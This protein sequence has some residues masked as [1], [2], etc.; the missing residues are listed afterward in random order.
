MTSGASPRRV[1]LALVALV[2]PA[3]T[4]TSDRAGGDD[5]AAL[6]PHLVL[7]ILGGGVRAAD[8]TDPTLMPTL[9]AMAAAKDGRALLE[10]EAGA[11]DGYAGAARLLT[12]RNDGVDGTARTR[13]PHP[14]L[15]EYVRRGRD[16][17][18]EKVWYVSFA[19]GDDLRLAWSDHEQFG[20]SFAPAVASGWGAFAEP[21]GA[22]LETFGRPLPIEAEAW[23]HLRRLRRM[24]RDAATGLLPSDV[25][26]GLPRAEAV[27][28]ALLRELDRK[29]LLLDVPN[30]RDEQALRAART[31]LEIHRPVLTI[32]R[33]G[34]AEQAHA[35]YA[36]Y[37]AVLAANDRGIGVLR[38]V[39]DGD[40]QMAARTIFA[41]VADRGRNAQPDAAGALGAD[42]ASRER[43][44]VAL[45]IQG[46]GV[47]RRG[48]ARIRRAVEDVC[49]TLGRLL[50]VETP[51]A[52]G[53]VWE[54]LFAVR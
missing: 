29:A 8:L 41:V 27:E 45:V 13:P 52:T 11:P 48:G 4:L 26:A 24:G 30:P 31:A 3:L 21:L 32:V 10:L 1:V 15:A 43:Q 50:G 49:P 53:V 35:S 51:Q 44:R 28:R 6:S 18:R 17:P 34:E 46:P 39:V 5:R 20:E 2:L 19:G 40:P 38:A 25:D 33:L 12:G 14:T 36:R 22:F 37:R 54:D 9:A 7:V 16:L 47:R 23:A 42:D